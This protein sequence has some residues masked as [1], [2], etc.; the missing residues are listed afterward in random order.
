MIVP[1]GDVPEEF[2]GPA[3]E[4]FPLKVP[5]A[6][7]F[8]LQF[9]MTG[10]GTWHNTKLGSLDLEIDPELPNFGHEALPVRAVGN[11]LLTRSD[12]KEIHNTHLTALFAYVDQ[13]LHEMTEAWK[14]ELLGEEVDQTEMA[15]RLPSKEAFKTFFEEMKAAQ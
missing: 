13:H 5:Q 1:K 4:W 10:S 8:P 3:V 7:G 11:A 15:E 12:H 9:T 6:L 2:S 14:R